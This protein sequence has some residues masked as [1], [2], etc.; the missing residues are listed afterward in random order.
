M[1]TLKFSVLMY[2]CLAL[3]STFGQAQAASDGKDAVKPPVERLC[4]DTS[5]QAE[6]EK[7][8]Q[9]LA[10]HLKLTDAQK[11]AF[12][13]FQDARIKSLA[14]S[15]AALCAKPPDLSSFESRLVFSQT[16]LETRLAALKADRKSVV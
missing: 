4:A 8:A 13:A 1:P 12:K 6:H 2:T 10:E 9:R 7:Y 5:N 3:A 15:K 14:D 16:F 11:A